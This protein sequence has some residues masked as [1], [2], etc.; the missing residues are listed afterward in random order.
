MS[1]AYFAI[2]LAGG[3]GR[4]PARVARGPVGER[5][6]PLGLEAEQPAGRP[7]RRTPGAWPNEAVCRLL[8]QAGE[9]D[10]EDGATGP[11]RHDDRDCCGDDDPDLFICPSFL[12]S[13]L[14]IHRDAGTC[15]CLLGVRV[16]SPPLSVYIEPMFLLI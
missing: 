11:P 2:G 3:A 9:G 13:D 16:Y 7:G 14:L 1:E 12:G 15:P 5:S 8:A 4:W 10:Q 6:E